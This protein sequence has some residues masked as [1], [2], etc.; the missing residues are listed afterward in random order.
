MVVLP[1]DHRDVTP[2]PSH[3]VHA[4][5]LI[6]HERSLAVAASAAEDAHRRHRIWLRSG[7]VVNQGPAFPVVARQSERRNFRIAR[8]DLAGSTQDRLRRTSIAAHG[9]AFH[10]LRSECGKELIES[11]AGSAAKTVNRRSG[12][13]TAN[14]LAS[15]PARRLVSLIWATLES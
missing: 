4:R 10:S 11:T 5:D 2:L 14:T 1:I 12:S 6:N 15:S 13:P 8:D 9:D 3:L 7:A